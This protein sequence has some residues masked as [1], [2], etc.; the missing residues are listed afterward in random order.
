MKYYERRYKLEEEEFLRLIKEWNK[1]DI[2]KIFWLV[3]ILNLLC[4]WYLWIRNDYLTKRYENLPIE[5]YILSTKSSLISSLKILLLSLEHELYLDYRNILESLIKYFYFLENPMKYVLY[6]DD[7]YLKF[8]EDLIWY[9]NKHPL[10]DNSS[11]PWSIKGLYHEISGKIHDPVISKIKITNF[12]N[13]IHYDEKII[14]S[15]LTIFE[16]MVKELI[17][18]SVIFNKN[19]VNGLSL[20]SRDLI[21]SFM[22]DKKFW[23]YIGT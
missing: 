7:N 16:R 9:F 3:Y 10:Y 20:E 2:K 14:K 21:I 13:E 12:L 1:T 18:F 19:T 23:T 8:S 22:H 17:W 15:A 4:D 11:V 5:N 6:K